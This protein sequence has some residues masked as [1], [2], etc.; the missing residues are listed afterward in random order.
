MSRTDFAGSGWISTPFVARWHQRSSY[1]I[2]DISDAL[3]FLS[4]SPRL[5]GGVVFVLL[6]GLNQNRVC[7]VFEDDTPDTSSLKLMGPTKRTVSVP[8]SVWNKGSHYI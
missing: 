8:I 5:N 6:S 3:I 7:G 1:V 2:F 4:T